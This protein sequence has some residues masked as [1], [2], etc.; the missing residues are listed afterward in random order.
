MP[1]DAKLILITNHDV[2][3]AP[4]LAA[5]AESLAELGRVVIVAPEND[6]SAAGHSLTLRRPLRVRE[7]GKDTFSVDG[8]PTDCVTVGVHRLLPARPDLVV[9]GINPGPNLGDDINYSGTVSAAVEATMLGIAA[10]AISLADYDATDFSVAARFSRILAVRILADGIPPDTLLNVNCPAGSAAEI[11]GIRFSRQ[12]RRAYE[13][14]ITAIADPWGRRHY[15]IGGGTPVDNGGADAD[16]A[17]I[18]AGFISIT[19]LRL[20]RTDHEA[21]RKLADEW[22]DLKLEP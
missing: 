13:G 17:A 18:A 16:T 15:W 22:Q 21:R 20:D 1:M 11:Q 14:A 2:I 5:L 8:T 7:R 12:G 19:P 10:F 6:S 9:S 4:G 3:R